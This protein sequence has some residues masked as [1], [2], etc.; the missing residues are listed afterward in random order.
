MAPSSLIAALP[1]FFD[2]AFRLAPAL[3]LTTAKYLGLALLAMNIG[4][5]PL[6]WH[7]RVFMVVFEARLSQGWHI[8]THVFSSREVKKRAWHRWFEA[9]QPIGLHPFRKVFAYSKFVSFDDADFYLHQSNSS[10]ARALDSVRFRL[11][12]SGFPNLFRAGGFSPLAATHFHFIREIP[13]LT[14][15]EVRCSI[16]SWDEKWFY[17][18]CRF[19]KPPSSKSRVSKHRL[20][21]SENGATPPLQESFIPNVT[22]PATPLTGDVTPALNGNAARQGQCAEP[23]AVSRALLA[24]AAQQTEPDGGLLYTVSVSQLCFKVGRITVPPAIILA[25]NG[26]YA[27]PDGAAANG[28]PPYWAKVSAM[29]APNKMRELGKFYRGGWR[30]V[31]AGERYWEEAFKACDEERVARL[32]PFGGSGLSGGLAG[33]RALSG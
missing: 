13:M 7:V 3:A 17:M 16:A 9:R 20:S 14:S 11:A 1:A 28:P 30:D 5:L 21:V 10:Y 23:D 12:L 19:V 6:V 25:T 22:A 32:A 8:L 2:N 27:S 33:A 4:S 18:V 15:Y 24:R 31:P 26:W 29:T